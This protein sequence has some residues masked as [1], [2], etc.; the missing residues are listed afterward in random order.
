M[1]TQQSCVFNSREV[2]IHNLQ[3]NKFNIQ[4]EDD[5][6]SALEKVLV[7]AKLIFIRGLHLGRT[8]MVQMVQSPFVVISLQLI[9]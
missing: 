8:N 6:N 5:H 9:F 2:F 3:F 4:Y 7:Q 1:A